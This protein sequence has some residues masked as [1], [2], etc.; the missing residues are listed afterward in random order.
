M[1][2]AVAPCRGAP[3]SIQ[4]LDAPDARPISIPTHV[5]WMTTSPGHEDGRLLR[6]ALYREEIYWSL[7]I[8]VIVRGMTEGDSDKVAA[9]YRLDGSSI[10][11]QLGLEYPQPV[12]FG[13]WNDWNSLTMKTGDAAF[14]LAYEDGRFT[15]DGGSPA[16]AAAT[17]TASSPCSRMRIEAVP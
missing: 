1:L 17:S 10:A 11:Q 16:Q 3:V 12:Q 15:I 6:V 4:P 5:S 2:S 14:T 9:S 8:E 7:Y 13:E